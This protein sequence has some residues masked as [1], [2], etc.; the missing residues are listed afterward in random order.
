MS[1]FTRS[2]WFVSYEESPLDHRMELTVKNADGL[3]VCSFFGDEHNFAD[4]RL[5]SAAPDVLE[6]AIE[7]IAARDA[8]DGIAAII[9]FGAAE[10]SLHAAIA[11]ATCGS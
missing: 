5:I 1:K 4:A 7:Y 3:Q 6:A 9:R 2:P 11:K 8:V 10:K